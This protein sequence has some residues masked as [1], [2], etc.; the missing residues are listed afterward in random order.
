MA[1]TR[2]TNSRSI[3]FTIA[4][5]DLA[6]LYTYIFQ[7]EVNLP[8]GQG[9]SPNAKLSWDFGDGGSDNSNSLKVTHT[10]HLSSQVWVTFT[11]VDTGWQLTRSRLL[12]VT[13]LP[14]ASF[15]L[16]VDS[17]SAPHM[18]F[19]DASSRA[20]G[21]YNWD[22]GDGLVGYGFTIPAHQYDVGTYTVKLAVTNA[23]GTSTTSRTF[24]VD[25]QII[26]PDPVTVAPPVNQTVATSLAGASTFLYTGNAPIQTGVAANTIVRKQ[27]AVLQGLVTD[28]DGTPLWNVQVSVLG[29]PE[30]GQTHTRGDGR[31]DLAVNGGNLLTLSYAKAG[32]LPVHRQAQPRWQGYTAL[33]PVVLLPL[34]TASTAIDL[35]PNAAL[36]VARGSV[37]TDLHGTRQ[38]TLFFPQ[39]T[40]ATLV[41]PD[42]TEQAA[43]HLTVRATE[44]TVGDSGPAAMPAALPLTSWYT[45]AVEFSADEALAAGATTVRFNQPLICYLENFLNFPV[46]LNKGTAANPAFVPVSI[47]AGSY[48]REQAAW[49]PSQDGQVVQIIGVTN[50]LAV[51]DTVGDGKTDSGAVLGITADERQQLAALY[52]VG[53]RLW[54]VPILHFTAE[55]LNGSMRLPGDPLALAP[56]QPEPLVGKTC[57]DPCLEQAP[58]SSARTRH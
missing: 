51:L 25:N 47:P 18:V 3:D 5:Q 24:T 27:A 13:D 42:G 29:H 57:P 53:Q 15:T 48:S 22:L 17:G 6:A 11:V 50:G 28:P 33:L 32:Y 20:S 12:S 16:A 10:Y 45:Y 52:P 37:Q 55:D 21:D 41:L 49:L 30:F 34:D 54:R 40:Q 7:G 26:L 38:A 39:G 36:Q 43:Q 14:D 56:N 1:T 4:F 23:I 46:G 9:L 44:Y 35:S 8:Q 31:F 2:T 19:C 58:R